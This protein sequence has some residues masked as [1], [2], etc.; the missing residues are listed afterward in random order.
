MEDPLPN[1]AERWAK[2]AARGNEA[3]P[4]WHT[5]QIKWLCSPPYRG[6]LGLVLTVGCFHVEQKLEEFADRVMS[7]GI[8]AERLRGNYFEVDAS[9]I[10]I[11]P[12]T[13]GDVARLTQVAEN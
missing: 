10:P 1:K 13:G 7:H 6:G 4:L 11:T 3:P 8:A 2:E 5:E 9:A 12:L